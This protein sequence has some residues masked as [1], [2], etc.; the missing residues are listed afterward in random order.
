M[1]NQQPKPETNMVWAILCTLLCCLPL[2]IVAI[3]NASKVDGLYLAGNYEAAKQASDNAKKYS[4]YGAI[5][6]VVGVILYFLFFAVVGGGLA[7]LG[8]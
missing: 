2:G 1:E 5:I 7:V 8:K 3:V 6:A 4:K